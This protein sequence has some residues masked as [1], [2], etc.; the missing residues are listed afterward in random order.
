[1]TFTP[2]AEQLAIVEAAATTTDNL[3]VEALAGAAKTS[4]LVLVAEALPK[5]EMLCLAFNKKIA[6][7]MSSRLPSN[8]KARTLNSLGHSAWSNTL[9]RRLI[10]DTKKTFRLL[11]AAIDELRDRDDQKEARDQFADIMRAID[12]GAACGYIPT[13]H[14]PAAAPLMEDDEFFGHLEEEPSDGA[15]KLITLVTLARL[16]EAW[17]GTIDFSDQILM[18]TVFKSVFDYYPLVLIDEAQDLSA[19]NHAMLRRVARKRLI[20][21]GDPNQAIYG[22]RGAHQNSMTLLKEQFSMTKLGLTISFRC[23]IAVVEEA[24][25]RTPHMQYPDW[26]AQGKVERL[27]S[28]DVETLSDL[29]DVAVICRNNA[30]LF[31]MAIRL[32]KDGRYPEL[33]GND[34]GR[35]LIK[36]LKKLGPDHMTQAAA[37]EAVLAWRDAK[38]IK[39]RNPERVQDQ[40]SCLLIFVDEGKNLGEAVAY[41]ERVM[42][43]AGP[44]KLM[45]GHKSKGLEFKD[46]FILDKD[47]LRLKEGQDKNLL[48]VMQTRSKDNLYYVNSKEYSSPKDLDE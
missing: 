38:L 40:A 47:L 9:G 33:V 8:C 18:P 7:E 19:L 30:P 16:K 2:T 1:M 45:T 13:G 28:W 3:L 20:A 5:T 14:Y 22:F 36:Q 37:R 25:W 23:P 41:A 29:H 46:V 11:S 12:F 17:A 15:K 44:I 6:D 31:S 10:L 26:A 4:T 34:L 35:S 48:Y 43:V 21:V 24:R 39:A 42:S 27:P 32:L